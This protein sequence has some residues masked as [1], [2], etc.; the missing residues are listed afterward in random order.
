M[1][2]Y[3]DIFP[4]VAK[5]AGLGGGVDAVNQAARLYLQNK[6]LIDA[7]FKVLGGLIHKGHKVSVVDAPVSI[8]APA[9]VAAPPGVEAR[10]VVNLDV[11]LFY[12]E[13]DKK[14]VVHDGEELFNKDEAEAVRRGKGNVGWGDRVHLNITPIDQNGDKF[15]PGDE[16]NKQLLRADGYPAFE[17][18]ISFDGGDSG[19]V[20]LSS[21]YD[22]FGC[23]PVLKASR[24]AQDAA[25]HKVSY[26]CRFVTPAG[27]L[28]A[29]TA[30]VYNLS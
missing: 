10:R 3:N 5:M 18:V 15:E 2:D 24:D 4:V 21:E 11:Q 30:L 26:I 13:R 19:P 1:A 25:G 20:G 14:R 29:S 8:P 27:N 28:I 6:G 17:H 23:T 9:P 22:D 16:A 12:V 7:I